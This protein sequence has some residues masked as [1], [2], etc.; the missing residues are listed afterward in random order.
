MFD[1]STSDVEGDIRKCMLERGW[2]EDGEDITNT[3]SLLERG[4]IESFTMMELIQ[5]LE[6]K[7]R[8]KIEDDEL[9][10]ENFETLLAI[11]EFVGR[12][13]SRE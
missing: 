11:S 3:E 1:P 10:P 2:L 7:Y 4:V 9:V 8:I 6:E 13:L 12:K 5:F